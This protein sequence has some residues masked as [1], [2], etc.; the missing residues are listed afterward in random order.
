MC[1]IALSIA[2]VIVAIIGIIGIVDTVHGWTPIV[3][4]LIAYIMVMAVIMMNFMIAILSTTYDEHNQGASTRARVGEKE[5]LL[6]HALHRAH[7]HFAQ[8]RRLRGKRQGAI[9]GLRKGPTGHIGTAL[10]PGRRGCNVLDDSQA[11]RYARRFPG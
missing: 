7:G 3:V 9:H 10:A 8:R 2:P 4:L 6:Q 5:V 1:T 11:R